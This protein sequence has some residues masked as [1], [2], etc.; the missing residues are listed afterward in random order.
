MAAQ[1]AAQPAHEALAA[2]VAGLTA[3]IAELREDRIRRRLL[4][5]ASGVLVQQLG[6]SPADAADHVVDLALSTG[7]SAEDLAADVI[8]AAAGAPVAET[9]AGARRL[10]RNAAAVLVC[11]SSG[12]AAVTLLQDGLRRLGAQ[13]LYLWRR[14]ETDCLE[15]AGHAGASPQEAVHWQWVPPDTPLHRVIWTGESWWGVDARLPGAGA[16]LQGEPLRGV[17]PLRRHGG[18]VGVALVVWP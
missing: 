13:A 8:N 14:T 6:V 12:E 16:G 7:L 4:D 11:D 9:P 1:P 5:L 17:M 3:E 18:V 15:L 2:A 10:R